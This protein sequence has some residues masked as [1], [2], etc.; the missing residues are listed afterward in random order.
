MALHLIKLSVGTESIEDL[1]RWRDRVFGKGQPTSHVTRM[2]P[3]RRDEILD[4]GSIYW[5]IKRVVQVRQRVLDLEEVTDSAGVKRCRLVLEPE[6]IRTNPAPKRPFQGWRYLKP[7][8]AP[9][10]LS[11]AAGGENL[12][13]DLRRKLLELGAW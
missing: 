2:F 6:L 3:K 13:E 11:L 7:E 1:E 5:V 9:G 4:G 10:D 12:P 8:D